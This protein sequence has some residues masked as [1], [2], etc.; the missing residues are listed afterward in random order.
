MKK[1]ILFIFLLPSLLIAQTQSSSQILDGINRLNSFTTVLYLAAHPDDENTRVIS[2]LENGEHARTAYLSITRG[3]GGQ[4]LIGNEFGDELG[5]LRTQELLSARKIDGGEQ[6]FTRAVDFGY[7]RNAT[8]TLEKWDEE[9]VLSDVVWVIR[10]FK[11]QLIITRF[12]PD[13]RAGHGHHTASAMLAVKAIEAAADKN[14]FP[15]QLEWVDAWQVQ[16]VYWNTSSWWDKQVEEDIKTDSTIW[17]ADIGGYNPLTGWSHNELGSLAR[18][19]HKCQGFG[20]A[21]DRGE[22][23]EFFRHLAGKTMPNG[24]V[25]LASP[26]WSDLGVGEIKEMI[27]TLNSTF[28]AEHPEKSINILAGIYNTL[29]HVKDDY[30]RELKQNQCKELIFACAGLHMEALADKFSYQPGGIVKIKANFLSRLSDNLSITGLYCGD[31][32]I[33]FKQPAQ[34]EKNKTLTLELDAP[35]SKKISNPYWLIKSHDEMYDVDDQQLIGTPENAPELFVTT[36]LLV[37]NIGIPIKIPVVYKWRDRV[38][39]ELQ[40][41]LIVAPPVTVTFSEPMYV[42]VN[43][44]SVNVRAL[45]KWHTDSGSFKVKFEANGWEISKS[46]WILENGSFDKEEWI[47][48]LLTPKKGEKAETIHAKVDGARANAYKEIKYNHIKTQVYMPVSEAKLSYLNIKKV[49]SKVGYIKG[50]GDLVDVGIEQ[51]GYKVDLL[52]ETSISTTEFSQYQAIVIGIRAYNTHEW[53]INYQQKLMDYINLGGN[54]I[55]QYNTASRFDTD[56][57]VMGPYPFKI[58][59]GRVTEENAKATILEKKSPIFRTPNRVGKADFKNWVQE[60]GLYFASEWDENYTP[61]ISWHD[62]GLD[63]EQGGLIMCPYGKG[64][65]FYTGISFFRQLPAG[66]PGAFRLLANMISYTSETK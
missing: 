43:E 34:F 54:V 8:E 5:I 35:V 31:A 7:S 13:E 14:K 25:D 32:G 63:E 39:G 4:N 24:M 60:R 36:T 18:S 9:A 62:Q 1:Y 22:Q 58:G 27:N 38:E 6:F 26:T 48:L 64:A 3:D 44:A 19:Q 29:N 51:M 57:K 45:V 59:R 50:A 17:K 46:E 42:A 49:G 11:P 2:W 10:K 41:D 61:L 12:P 66:V 65:Y 28:D 56:Q 20:V 15:E 53:L 47:N 52:D 37:N 40:R 33:A 55:V 21:I 30:W 23:F 16:S